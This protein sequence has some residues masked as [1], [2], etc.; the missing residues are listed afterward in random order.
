MKSLN[1]L[2]E[3]VRSRPGGGQAKIP[4]FGRGGDG[5]GGQRPKTRLCTQNRPPISGPFNK[6]YFFLRKFL[7]W[8][9]RTLYNDMH[10]LGFR[11]S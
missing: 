2:A 4:D 9:R 5:V 6:F 7:M 1:H 10:S 3:I 8:G 11:S